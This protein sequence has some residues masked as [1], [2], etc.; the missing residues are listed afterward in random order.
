MKCKDFILEATNSVNMKAG[1]TFEA[2]AGTMQS[3]D[4]GS[5][6]IAQASMIKIN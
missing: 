6:M 1:Q 2:K 4:G 3:F 5:S